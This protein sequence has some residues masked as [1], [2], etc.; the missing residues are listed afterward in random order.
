M[1]SKEIDIAEKLFQMI[2]NLS[3]D[4]KMEL[5]NK[6]KHSLKKAE[7][8]SVDDSWK[9]LFGAWESDESA[10]DHYINQDESAIQSSN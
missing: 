6:I 5:F 7:K 1:K 3:A 10:E 8:T 2:N 9:E 4:V